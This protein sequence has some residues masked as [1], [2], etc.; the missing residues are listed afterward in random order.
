MDCRKPL[1]LGL[2]RKAKGQ[3][4]Q[5][6]GEGGSPGHFPFA[7][8]LV[9]VAFFA[10]GAVGCTSWGGLKKSDP[11]A[12]ATSAT[13]PPPGVVV[14]KEKEKDLPPRT[15]KASTCVALA[16]WYAK[17]AQAP[18]REPA[19]VDQLREVARKEYQQA[20]SIDPNYLPTYQ[21]LGRLY[22][23]MGDQAR[24]MQTFQKGLSINSKHAALW[25]DLGMCQ[26]RQKSWD[27]AIQSL[28]KAVEYDPENREYINMLGHTLSRTGRYQESLAVF[29][30]SYGEA[31]AYYNV[32][33]MLQHLG[34]AELSKQY[35]QA[36]L[37]KDPTLE[38]A[39]GLLAQLEGRAPSNIQRV[40]YS[41]PEKSA[42]PGAVA[43]PNS[44][45][46]QPASPSS[47]VTP[48][49]LPLPTPNTSAPPGPILPPDPLVPTASIVPP[50]AVVPPAPP[51]IFLRQK[52][53]R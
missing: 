32:A 42:T 48:P 27:P 13:T 36:A 43:T 46:N 25:Y 17:E 31:K 50:E 45:V 47:L 7:F 21:A 40:G 2:T 29:S 23:A 9:P 53:P 34:Q 41:E 44:S 30:R 33:R 22:V 51:P 1:W 39:Q 24:A 52:D 5:A 26:L 14:K 18:N 49:Q 3:R 35:V 20:L 28:T 38:P 8:F 6:K 4:I 19:Q 16:D 11:V 37:Q 12:A 10:G 15:P